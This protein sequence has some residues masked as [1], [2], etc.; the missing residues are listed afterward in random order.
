MNRGLDLIVCIKAV[1]RDVPAGPLIRSA[2]TCELN[3][4]DVPALETAFRLRES[5]GG[6]VTV[7]SLGPETCEFVVREALSMGADRGYLVSDPALA[8]SDTLATSKALGAALEKVAPFDVLLL[9]TRSSDSDTGQVGPQ[10]AEFLRIPLVTGVRAVEMKNR[11]LIIDRKADGFIEKVE[12]DLPAALTV[13]P[14]SDRAGYV[15]LKAI[16]E[17][18]EERDIT[19]WGMQDIQLAPGQVGQTGSPTEVL[20]LSRIK[21][22][23]KCRFLEGTEEEQADE[24]LKLLIE[25]GMEW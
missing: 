5:H 10:I 24:L 18:Y 11:T 6:K 19:R 17:A 22:E 14:S 16:E 21:R 1:I 2:E 9:G 4:Y 3:P 13:H 25:W 8:G 20:T 12:V 7:M 15:G 23:R